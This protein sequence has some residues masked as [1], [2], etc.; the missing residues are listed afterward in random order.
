MQLATRDRAGANSFPECPTLC[1]DARRGRRD[2]KCVAQ[3]SPVDRVEIDSAACAVL[4]KAAVGH[5]GRWHFERRDLEA[6]RR[7]G[8]ARR[9]TLIV[10]VADDEIEIVMVARLSS[11]ER[12]D[13]P[14]TGEPAP[15]SDALECGDDRHHVFRSHLAPHRGP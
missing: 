3:A 1:R 8:L 4:E 5:P 15:H 12:V 14:A 6:E 10:E 13:T 2:P 7:Q 9:N 11:K